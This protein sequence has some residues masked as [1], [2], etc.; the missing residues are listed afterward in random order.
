MIMRDTALGITGDGPAAIERG[1]EQSSLGI[2]LTATS[3]KG[4][5]TAG[6]ADGAARRRG[7]RWVLV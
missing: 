3:C 5:T 4:T 2:V 7:S 6:Y 1:F